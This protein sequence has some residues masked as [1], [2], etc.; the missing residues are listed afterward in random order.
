MGVAFRAAL[1]LVLVVI[2]GVSVTRG[3][4]VH[5]IHEQNSF[6]ED[7]PLLH[8]V[9]L[10]PKVL[11]V[12]LKTKWAKQGLE[13]ANDSQRDN[14]AQLF[15]AAEIHLTRWDDVDLVVIG[16]PPM[17]GADNCWFWVV[18]SARNHPRVVLVGGGNSLDGWTAGRAATETLGLPGHRLTTQARKSIAST[19]NHI[20]FGKRNGFRIDQQLRRQLPSSRVTGHRDPN[21]SACGR[22]PWIPPR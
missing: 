17:R 21:T 12:L 1:A 2:D 19:V 9:P 20:G 8:A 10:T 6:H 5:S 15:R 7:E 4:E 16:I 11:S 14:P 18:R 3:Q 22:R 13:F